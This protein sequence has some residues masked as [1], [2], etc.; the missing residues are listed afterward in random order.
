MTRDRDGDIDDISDL[1][2][3]SESLASDVNELIETVTLNQTH[4]EINFNN[5][6][7]SIAQLTEELR[8]LR[9]EVVEARRENRAL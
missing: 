8:A 6:T 9:F 7:V 1:N 5:V 3:I 4:T 2:D